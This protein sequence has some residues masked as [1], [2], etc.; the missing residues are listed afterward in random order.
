[1]VR[2]FKSRPQLM[3]DSVRWRTLHILNLFLNRTSNE[4]RMVAP[5]IAASRSLDSWYL[6]VN[7]I[8][9]DRNFHR[10]EFSIFTHLVEVFGG[11]SLLAS[12]KAKASVSPEEFVPKAI[13]WWMAL[14]G[15]VGVRSVEDMLWWKFPNVC[16]YCFS[17][18]HRP[19]D[20][21]QGD[22]PHFLQWRE[23]AGLA[24]RNLHAK[25]STIGDWQKLFFEIYPV[26]TEDYHL[27]FARFSEEL[28]EL[29]EALRVAP[30]APGYFL[31]EA[32]DVFAWLMHLQNLIE[33]KQGIGSKGLGKAL[34]D[35]FAASYP[36]ACKDCGSPVCT[37]PPILPGTLGR[38]AHEVPVGESPFADGRVLIPV[39]DALKLFSVGSSHVR[40]HNEDFAISATMLRDIRE[41]VEAVSVEVARHKEISEVAGL[42]VAYA[43]RRIDDLLATQRLTQQ[44]I[45][46][47]QAIMTALPSE[48]RQAITSV[49]TNIASA[50]W[51]AAL[52]QFLGSAS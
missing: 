30:I 45:D 42:D 41:L 4:V 15:K 29:A 21:K 52:L 9:L 19:A 32:A 20:C 34:N 7:G 18:P 44:N 5:E 40:I 43:V 22:G 6:T 38:I 31:S 39:E 24:K 46:D 23:L 28:G 47:L 1:M 13:A 11:L 36:D 35:H 17:S 14:C 10:T 27:T 37:C 3:D 16:P 26:G 12:N 48:S 49:L 50:P 51:A 33:I 25:P 8:Y 2:T